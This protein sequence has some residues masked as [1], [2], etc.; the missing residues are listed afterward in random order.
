MGHHAL[1]IVPGGDER[2]GSFGDSER[3]L[4]LFSDP[5]AR[6]ARRWREMFDPEQCD[7]M[8]AAKLVRSMP[9]LF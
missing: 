2:G 5:D 1:D 3:L 8:D 7:E 9:S 4:P 6:G